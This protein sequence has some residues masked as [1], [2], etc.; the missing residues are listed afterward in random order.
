MSSEQ[1]RVVPAARP[2]T[3]IELIARTY[4][5]IKVEADPDTLIG[6]MLGAKPQPKQEEPHA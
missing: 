5:G 2:A 3:V 6:R 1:E 4:P